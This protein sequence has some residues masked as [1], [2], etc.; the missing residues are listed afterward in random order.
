MCSATSP[1]EQL[2]KTHGLT[3][4]CVMH[5]PMPRPSGACCPQRRSLAA[6]HRT[7]A[8]V[9]NGQAR[10]CRPGKCRIGQLTWAQPPTSVSSFPAWARDLLRLKHACTQ[11]SPG[12]STGSWL[13]ISARPWAGFQASHAR[14]SCSHRTIQ[15]LGADHLC[16]SAFEFQPWQC[17]AEHQ[18]S[19]SSAHRCLIK[20]RDRLTQAKVPWKIEKL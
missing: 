3:G 5:T 18:P 7:A 17:I 19:D 15:R 4:G 6:V 9:G 8:C 16:R 13:D 1:P 10:S 20:P 11:I 12:G 14:P 2:A